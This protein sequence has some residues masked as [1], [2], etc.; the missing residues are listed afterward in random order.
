MSKVIEEL[1]RI[2]S[3]ETT[4]KPLGEAGDE[5]LS[6]QDFAR[7]YKKFDDDERRAFVKKI[8][9]G[10]Q[11]LQKGRTRLGAVLGDYSAA[12]VYSAARE[13]GME[14][15]QITGAVWKAVLKKE[16]ELMRDTG[17]DEDEDEGAESRQ[18][19]GSVRTE[20][21]GPKNHAEL[22]KNY[23][24]VRGAET[25]ASG[26]L[27]ESIART[28][29]EIPPFSPEGGV[30]QGEGG[31]GGAMNASSPITVPDN[32]SACVSDCMDV[33]VD[34]LPGV[35]VF[36]NGI[37][38]HLAGDLDH[39]AV[40]LAGQA[41]EHAR[42]LQKALG[43][44]MKLIGME[45]PGPVGGQ[46][47]TESRSAKPISEGRWNTL[48]QKQRER[49]IVDALMSSYGDGDGVQDMA[50]AEKW[51]K[52]NALLPFEKL[53]QKMDA[54]LGAG[55]SAA[56]GDYVES[57]RGRRTESKRLWTDMSEGERLDAI[58]LALMAQS[59]V[60]GE[61]M[62]WGEASEMAQQLNSPNIATTMTKMDM[63]MGDGTSAPLRKYTDDQTDD[64]TE[65]AQLNRHLIGQAGPAF[66]ELTDTER[67][68]LLNQNFG[69]GVVQQ[70]KQAQNVSSF[71]DVVDV[72]RR[73]GAS[74]GELVAMCDELIDKS[75]SRG[76]S[77]G[78]SLAARMLRALKG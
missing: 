55:S 72:L 39:P 56:M 31:E 17:G 48:S 34:L 36:R 67:D 3:G 47:A 42:G 20:S 13:A 21:L 53:K 8:G 37:E 78:E 16:K 57:R 35:E 6:R 38:A 66:Y 7:E 32:L 11:D 69:A 14:P 52:K 49:A 64:Q 61:E 25:V 76:E 46:N 74:V 23:K 63:A 68:A 43:E 65:A 28:E 71:A 58:G 40:A 30:G 54:E 9:L 50:D 15:M 62:S 51:A 75:E 70:L 5:K 27:S 45:V 10:I 59:D 33:V 60:T 29:D 22:K 77:R 41:F 12:N 19:S 4:R 1:K 73:A 18:L 44:T 26:N 2:Q 24:V